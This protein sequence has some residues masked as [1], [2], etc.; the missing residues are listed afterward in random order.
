M[1][2]RFIQSFHSCH[3]DSYIHRYQMR[4]S[5]QKLDKNNEIKICVYISVF[6]FLHSIGLEVRNCFIKKIIDFYPLNKT[7]WALSKCTF[8]LKLAY[9]V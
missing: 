4:H 6:D 5:G 3:C 8:P 9:C 1:L 2:L 7:V